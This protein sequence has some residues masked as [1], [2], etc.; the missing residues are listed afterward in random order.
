M[1]VRY[2]HIGIGRLLASPQATLLGSFAAVI[3]AGALVLWLP[4]LHASDRVGFVE[5][6]FTSTSAVCVTGLV[7]VDTGSDFNLAGQV[8]ILALIQAGGLGI[9]TLAAMAFHLAGRRLSLRSQALVSDSFFQ[10]DIAAEFKDTFRRILILVFSIEGIGALLLFLAL[11]QRPDLKH[12]LFS[13]VFHSISAFC[14][15]GFSIYT[16]NF[17][18]IANC[19][20]ALIVVMFL[21]VLGGLGSAVLHELWILARTRVSRRRHFRANRMSLH[22]KL[23]LVISA[24][25]IFGG[26]VGLALF[27]AGDSEV[28]WAD[29]VFHALFQSVTARTAGFNT[30]DMARLPAASLFVL[31]MLMFVGGSPGSCAGGVKTTALAIWLSRLHG[32]VHGRTEVRILD[33]RLSEDLVNRA[34]L[35]LGVAVFWNLLGIFVLLGTQ[36][37]L[38]VRP[39]DLI[40][41][42]VSAFGTVGLSTGVTPQLSTLGKLWICATM[43]V[44]RLGPLTVAL[45]MFSRTSGNVSYPKGMVMIG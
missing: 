18:E 25:L 31:I 7:V 43:F 11:S 13:A 15:A 26:A 14:N 32:S 17:I 8:M 5:A 22:G 35:L 42:Q 10:K 19:G 30:V 6:L 28:H 40:F 4:W 39:L 37:D 16:D 45:W 29:R 1:N 44:G 2:R 34:D 12:R 27:G 3:F 38:A 9:M 33:R 20:E 21:I 24:L 41:E 23:V 36:S